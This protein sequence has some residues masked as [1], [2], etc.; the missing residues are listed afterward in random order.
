MKELIGEEKFA[1]APIENESQERSSMTRSLPKTN[2]PSQDDSKIIR[3]GNI[4]IT[5][6]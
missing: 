5:R 2:R 4:T 1:A 3:F 6:R